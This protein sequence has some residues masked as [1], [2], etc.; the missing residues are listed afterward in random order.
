MGNCLII[1]TEA[2]S[3]LTSNYKEMR[4]K[5]FF[6]THA[7]CSGQKRTFGVK[8]KNAQGKGEEFQQETERNQSA[9]SRAVLLA[10]YFKHE[11]MEAGFKHQLWQQPDQV[12]LL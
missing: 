1:P 6:S 4:Q 10:V 9:N 3:L 7:I 11:K 5:L 2:A 8:L 12:F